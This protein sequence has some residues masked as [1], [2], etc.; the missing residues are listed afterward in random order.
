MK[1]AD[2]IVRGGRLVLEDELRRADLVVDGGKIATIVDP[3]DRSYSADDE[4]DARR[5]HVL[6][7]LVDAH[8][9][10]N[11]PGHAEREG[12]VTGTRA[13][14]AG[15]VT[16]VIDMPLSCTPATTSLAAL[17]LKRAVA[18]EAAIVDYGHWGGLV[19]DNVEAMAALHEAACWASKRSWPRQASRISPAPP[20]ACSWR[21]CT[22]R[23]GWA[24]WY[25]STPRTR[26]LRS[27][28]PPGCWRRA[29]AIPWRGPRDVPRWRSSRVSTAH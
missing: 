1:R 16:T 15:G 17:A 11:D 22:R 18:A 26:R 28:T 14:A 24:P 8:V 2:L 12:Y 9:H 5:K 29:D 3:G 10:F 23:R 4:I 25:S 19:T 13:A 6:P 27:T 21:A 20:T 7:G